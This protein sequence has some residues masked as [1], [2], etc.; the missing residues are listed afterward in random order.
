MFST[1]SATS[2]RPGPTRRRTGWFGRLTADVLFV[3]RRDRLIWLLPLIVLLLLMAGL[4]VAG[5]SL[6]PLAPFV[7]PLF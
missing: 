5:T 1:S 3:A 6:G 4:I 7:Y 2:A